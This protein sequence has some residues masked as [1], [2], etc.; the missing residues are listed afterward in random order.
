MALETAGQHADQRDQ[1]EAANVQRRRQPL[2]GFPAQP[3]QIQPAG[4]IRA[5]TQQLQQAKLA[6][7]AHALRLG[8]AGAGQV[9]YV[10]AERQHVQPAGAAVH[11]LPGAS[12][13]HH[14]RTGRADQQPAGFGE[15]RVRM[16]PVAAIID[17][18]AAQAA[19]RRAGAGEHHHLRPDLVEHAFLQGEGIE[20]IADFKQILAEQHSARRHHPQIERVAGGDR[21]HREGQRRPGQGELRHAGGPHHRQLPIIGQPQI[22]PQHHPEATDRQDDGNEIGDFQPGQLE[23]HQQGLAVID[24]DLDI[25]QGRNQPHQRGQPERHRQ[26]PEQQLTEHINVD[27]AQPGHGG[28]VLRTPRRM[29]LW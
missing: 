28:S 5:G 14:L 25:A 26:H 8:A 20:L 2:I 22:N 19:I 7:V 24:D 18:D 1:H 3:R 29:L 27:A 11:L 4:K 15:H 13:Q 16:Q 17:H 21:G 12:V 6:G 10:L 23:K 9:E